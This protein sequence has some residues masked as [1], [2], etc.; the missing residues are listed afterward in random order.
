MTYVASDVTSMPAGRELKVDRSFVI[1]MLESDSDRIV[2]QKTIE[3]G[4]E[5]DMKG[6]AEG[7]ETA[8]Q[9]DFLR[10]IGCDI[11]QGY[12]F[13]RPLPVGQWMD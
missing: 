12:L 11:A 10:S 8:Q 4:H 13:S 9:L 7:G 5:L 1:N 2:V 6:V 3:I